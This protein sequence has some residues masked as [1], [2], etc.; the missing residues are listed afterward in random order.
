MDLELYIGLLLLLKLVS[1]IGFFTLHN[2]PLPA[3]LPG[4]RLVGL[5]QVGC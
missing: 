3:Q 2:W 1:Q 5:G 4:R